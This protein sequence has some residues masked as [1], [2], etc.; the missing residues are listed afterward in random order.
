MERVAPGRLAE[1]NAPLASSMQVRH[2]ADWG[3]YAMMAAGT[4]LSPSHSGRT[5]HQSAFCFFFLPVSVSR[6]VWKCLWKARKGRT[7][8]PFGWVPLPRQAMRFAAG[9]DQAGAESVSSADTMM[10]SAILRVELEFLVVLKRWVSCLDA[11]N[12]TGSI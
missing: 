10:G 6:R 12:S 2:P 3:T 4:S 1:P 8:E 11:I 5:R 7:D 9:A